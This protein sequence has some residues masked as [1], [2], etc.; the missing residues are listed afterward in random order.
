M[1]A[2]GI[3][4][5]IINTTRLFEII[6]FVLAFIMFILFSQFKK[7]HNALEVS[8]QTTALTDSDPLGIADELRRLK[9]PGSSN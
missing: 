3:T 2:H 5:T 4:G 6:C 8:S 7:I 9:T 1:D